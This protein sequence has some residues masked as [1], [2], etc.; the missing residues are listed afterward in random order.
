[1]RM[2][3]YKRQEHVAD[4]ERVAA[5]K[6]AYEPF[7]AHR[8]FRSRLPRQDALDRF[9][10]EHSH[11]F[12]FAAHWF[13]AEEYRVVTLVY[14][15]CR[16]TDDL[17]DQSAPQPAGQVEKQLTQ[18]LLLTRKAYKEGDAGIPWLDELM[19]V[20][21]NREVP[22]RLVSDL[23]TGV[24][25]DIGEV[26][27][28]SVKALHRYAHRV[29]SVVGMWLCHLFDVHE[30]ATLRRAAALGRAMQ[31]TNILRD[32]G[33][34]LRR[35][36]I[37]LPA[38]LMKRFGVTQEDLHAMASGAQPI[39]E[40]YKALIEDLMERADADYRYAFRGLAGVPLSFAR[41]SAVAAEVYRGIHRGI[42]GNGY[43]NF[44]H[45]A[46]TRWPEKALLA[47][48]GLYRLRRVRRLPYHST[49]FSREDTARSPRSSSCCPLTYVH[50]LL[51]NPPR[52][53]C[54]DFSPLK[55]KLKRKRRRCP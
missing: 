50:A 28:P 18:W 49:A 23:V 47:A 26:A 30:A 1:M 37:Y 33:E 53:S 48:R 13:S 34:D 55:R 5:G 2:D 39:M 24:R 31:T 21:A 32:V 25:M 36:R 12:S 54:H 46:Y 11:S 41:A 29:A 51:A 40:S 52:T 16:T 17:A 38:E 45:R 15:F 9:F 43:D 19:T 20:S 10:R 3:N 4:E 8:I 22:F 44:H 27:L 14:A 6:T 42:R 35:Q 7:D